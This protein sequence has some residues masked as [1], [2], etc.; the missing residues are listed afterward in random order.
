M[1]AVWRG[2]WFASPGGTL[3]LSIAMLLGCNLDAER[4]ESDLGLG[5]RGAGLVRLTT[6]GTFASKC[7]VV[8][9]QLG[10]QLGHVPGGSDVVWWAVVGGHGVRRQYVSLP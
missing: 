2:S 9:M 4:G 1:G 7:D 5:L 6:G 3:A 8:W 10:D